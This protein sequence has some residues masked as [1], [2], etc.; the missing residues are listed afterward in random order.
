MTQILNHQC[1]L[2]CKKNKKTKKN[3]KIDS[4]LNKTKFYDHNLKNKKI[5]KYFMYWYESNSIIKKSPCV[6]SSS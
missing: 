6:Q 5:K 2:V 4:L 3:L 1:L